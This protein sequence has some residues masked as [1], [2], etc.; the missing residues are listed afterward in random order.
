MYKRQGQGGLP[1]DSGKHVYTN[2]EVLATKSVMHH[3]DMNPFNFP[4]NQ[5]LR[6]NYGEDVCSRTLDL[7]RR[8]VFC[9]INPDWTDEQVDNTIKACR[10]AAGRL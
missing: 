3:P 4:A 6:M 2:W 9:G 1:I 10:D 8:T 5:G 7:L